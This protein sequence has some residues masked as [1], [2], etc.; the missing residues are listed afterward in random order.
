M[1]F[2]T[3]SFS[4]IRPQIFPLPPSPPRGEKQHFSKSF[5]F[6]SDSPPCSPHEQSSL[7]PPLCN[8][9]LPLLQHFLLLRCC[10]L[11]FGKEFFDRRTKEKPMDREM[12]HESRGQKP[13]PVPDFRFASPFP[14]QIAS[15]SETPRRSVASEEEEQLYIVRGFSL[16]TL[17]CSSL[18][19]L[20]F[21]S[22]QR[23]KERTSSIYP[24]RFPN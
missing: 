5:P 3:F 7:N 20:V 15:T 16:F 13:L 24:C 10:S 14:F 6:F 21:P 19:Y 2:S 4:S 17:S 12:S 1:M 23:R 9:L 11:Y 22:G 18:C 8:F